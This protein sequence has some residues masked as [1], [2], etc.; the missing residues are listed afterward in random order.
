MNRRCGTF[1]KI[2]WQMESLNNIEVFVLSVPILAMGVF[3]L[4]KLYFHLEYLKLHDEQLAGESLFDV[5]VNP[6]LLFKVFYIFIPIFIKSER[7]KEGK[8][9][10]LETKV[11]KSLSSFWLCLTMAMFVAGILM[12]DKSR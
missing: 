1:F 3:H 9:L 12:I 8:E 7:N 5:F 6:R 2:D 11:G 4:R 10:E